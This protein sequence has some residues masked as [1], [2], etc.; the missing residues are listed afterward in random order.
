MSPLN[1]NINKKW[2][3]AVKCFYLICSVCGFEPESLLYFC[4]DT[5]EE[6]E[7]DEHGLTFLNNTQ[8]QRHK[9]IVSLLLLH[10][11]LP[12][13]TQYLFNISPKM[14]K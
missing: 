14:S 2:G 12:L 3:P 4:S 8:R 1:P 9:E 11:S 7:V 10:F 5:C 13:P 6:E